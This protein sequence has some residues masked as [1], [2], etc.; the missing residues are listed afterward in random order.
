MKRDLLQNEG[1]RSN[2]KTHPGRWGRLSGGGCG[3]WGSWPVPVSYTHLA[4][5]RLCEE[6]PP[7]PEELEG[8][9]DLGWMLWDMDYSDASQILPLFFRAKL[10][11]GILEVPARDSEEVRG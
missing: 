9:R 2:E 4:H 8:A 11:D 7:C 5:F 1:A 10:Q 3:P 6:I